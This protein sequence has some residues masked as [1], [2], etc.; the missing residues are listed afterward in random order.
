VKINAFREIF[1]LTPSLRAQSEGEGHGQQPGSEGGHHR[2]QTQNQ[3]E[4]AASESALRLSPEEEIRAVEAAID[5]FSREA[6]SQNHGLSA[7][8]KQATPSGGA[9][10][11][12]VVLSDIEG[13]VIRSFSAAEFLKLR[14]AGS[15]DTRGRG[16][17]LD[18]K[19]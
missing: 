13:K 7:S 15:R 18:Q 10:G 14:Q 19:C 11:L 1:R 2:A 4:A 12:S 5:A 9:P 16:K 3:D 17:L 8:L 6:H